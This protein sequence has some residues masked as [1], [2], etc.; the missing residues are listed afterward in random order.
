MSR[1]L[2]IVFHVLGMPFDADT[3]KTSSLGG[4]ESAAYYQARELARRGHRVVVF[5]TKEN[6]ASGDGVIYIHCGAVNEAT[7]LG[8]DF[9]HYARNTSH[10]IL[11]SQRHP[12][13]FQNQFASKGNIW[14]LHDL[15]LLRTAPMVNNMMWNV[16]R[17]TAVSQFH[18]DQIVKV[19]G[20]DPDFIDVV[21]NG[22]DQ[23][24]Y[25]DVDYSKAIVSKTAD[26]ALFGK[27]GI[28]IGISTGLNLLY[29][30]RPERGLENLVKPGGIMEQLIG[31]DA[32]LHYCAYAN[33]VGEMAGYYDQLN[34]WARRLPNVTNLGSLTKPELAELQKSCDLLIYP[35][36]FEEVSCISMMEAMHAGLP[37][38]TTDAG[39]LLETLKNGGARIIS[40]QDG[41]ADC[42]AFAGF[43]KHVMDDG[44]EWLINAR[45]RQHA[46]A[47]HKTWAEVARVLEETMYSVLKARSGSNVAIARDAIEHS[48]LDVAWKAFHNYFENEPNR[49]PVM[50]KLRLE[51]SSLYAFTESPEAY[52]AHYA[53][54]Q[55]K[56]YDE[57]ED[58]VI[59]EDVTTSTRFRG[60]LNFVGQKLV[61]AKAPMRVLDYG[62]AHGHYIVPFAK[63]FSQH[64]F[65]GVDISARAIAAATK[66]IQRDNLT[67]VELRIG[68]EE[69]LTA[70]YLCNEKLIPGTMK[71]DGTTGEMVTEGDYYERELF[72]IVYAG[73]VVEH[74][75][76]PIALLEKFRS[77]LKPGGL[78]VVTTPTGRWEWTGTSAFREAREHLVHF[79]KA[80][81]NEI[82]GKNQVEIMT[83]PAGHDQTGKPLGSLV[84]G[85]TVNHPFK[86]IDIERKTNEWVPRQTVSVCL[87][88]KDGER[89]IRKCLE[90]VIDWVDEIVVAIDPS[91]KDRTAMIIDQIRDDYPYKAIVVVP[92]P[93]SAIENGFHAARNRSIES[94]SCDWILWM[95]ADEEIQQPW[96]L[97]KYLR[98]SQCQGISFPQI[99]YAVDPPGVLTTDYPC[100]LFRNN[101]GIQFFGYVHEHPE[102]EAGKAV[103]HAA[104]RGDVQFL[105]SGYVDESVRRKRYQRNLPL[106]EREMK[107]GKARGLNKFLWLRDIAQGIIF[108]AEMH[109]GGI[110]EAQ[111]EQA[112][113]GIKLFEEMVESWE[114]GS[115]MILDSVQF[116][117]QCVITLN[118]GFDVDVTIGTVK[119]PIRD[120]AARCNVKGRF[121]SREFF[122]KILTKVANEATKH[123]EEKYL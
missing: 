32:H 64:K 107:E 83:A 16:D 110:T 100:R 78:L 31:T 98:P 25:A 28:D 76:D 105:H 54:H 120:L 38:V 26:K 116:Y 82:C 92:E 30:S 18:K 112:K 42:E 73:E 52:E 50:E 108:F 22:V 13:A 2:E 84:W 113:E 48:D 68:T 19:Y 93:L 36:E 66:W 104:L 5:T 79:T 41:K 1:K 8:Q 91:T 88:V 61:N 80:D 123:Y 15:A 121:H 3:V 10:D 35:T 103:K 65:V 90:S 69:N 33:T 49:T 119:E 67:N 118:Q 60:V 11:I 14:Q 9:E 97:W 114:G 27:D 46:A 34:A 23:S 95:D 74:V 75:I 111:L 4:S 102:N 7:P 122:N 101:K 85:V 57:F 29:Q 37:V 96:N 55:T 70:E 21:P 106:L 51:L 99:H 43:V 44:K 45:R 40:L 20:F 63:E 39:A 12:L 53:K 24:L 89:T 86:G 77:I 62:C 94:A 47:K 81:I 6:P 71:E 117:S 87:I 56:Y 109:N 17:V 59:G 72:D 58:R 115:R